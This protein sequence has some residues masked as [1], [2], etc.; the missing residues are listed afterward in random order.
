MVG[1]LRLLSFCGMGI[2]SSSALSKIN[3]L[4][5]VWSPLSENR[6]SFQVTS[7]G[8]SKAAL[9][10]AFVCPALMETGEPSR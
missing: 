6:H 1:G 4:S 10:A 8:I 9:F 3:D 2:L 7:P 5:C